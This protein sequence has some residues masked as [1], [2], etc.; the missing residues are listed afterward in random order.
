MRYVSRLRGWVTLCALGATVVSCGGSPQLTTPG[1]DSG[2]QN[3]G[4]A[5]GSGGNG[6]T[7]GNIIIDPKDAAPP[8]PADQSTPTDGGGTAITC[9][10]GVIQSTEK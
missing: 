10:D 3:T 7:G 4:G 5:G 8:P 6:G 9:G 1:G 2:S